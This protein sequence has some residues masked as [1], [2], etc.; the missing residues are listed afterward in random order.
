MLK[1]IHYKFILIL[2]IYVKQAIKYSFAIGVLQKLLSLY[3]EVL[4]RPITEPNFMTQLYYLTDDMN[5]LCLIVS[6]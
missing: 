1:E 4:I 2:H 5:T 6:P 3:T